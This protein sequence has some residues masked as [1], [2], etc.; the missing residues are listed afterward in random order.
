MYREAQDFGSCVR[1]FCGVGD[2]QSALKIAL[3]SNDPQACFT[4]ARHFE[5]EGNIS[6]AILYYSKSQR[7][8]HAIRLAKDNNFD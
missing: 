3:S 6:D 2:T 4:L 1:M 8:H 7:L 5:A